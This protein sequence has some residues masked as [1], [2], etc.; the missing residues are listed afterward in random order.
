MVPTDGPTPLPSR[1]AT[2]TDTTAHELLADGRI[3]LVEYDPKWPYLFQREADRV[4]EALGTRALRLEHV[5]STAVPGMVANPCV[6]MVLVVPDSADESDY[7]PALEKVGYTLV[8]REPE[9]HERRLLSGPDVNV[10]VHVF[11]DGCDEVE[12]M[13]RFRDRLR[14]DSDDHAHY[15]RTKR[16]LAALGW[17]RVRDYADA[18][19]EV[20]AEILT[21]A[22]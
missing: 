11:S 19:S 21:R 14:A 10:N 20:V 13:L 2:S 7:L 6:D 5:G 1:G 9:R 3:Q 4:R 18:K 17:S 16:E 15:V 8:A 12:R 22:G